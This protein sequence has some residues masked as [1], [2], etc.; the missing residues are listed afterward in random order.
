MKGRECLWNTKS[1]HYTKVTA[2]KD[3]LTASVV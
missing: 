1:E 2:G 3:A